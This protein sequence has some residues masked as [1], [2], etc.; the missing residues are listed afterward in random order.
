MFITANEKR[1]HVRLGKWERNSA[2]RDETLH[3]MHAAEAETEVS[4]S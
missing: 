4:N 2:R 1:R 3:I